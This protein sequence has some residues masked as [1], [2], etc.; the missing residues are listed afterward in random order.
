MQRPQTDGLHPA[1]HSAASLPLPPLGYSPLVTPDR[2]L[3]E[4]ARQERR[5]FAAA[6]LLG[7]LAGLAAIAA[8]AALARAVA[9]AAMSGATLAVLAP[10][11]ALGL[12]AVALRAGLGW[13]SEAL[14][15]GAAARI[16][17]RLRMRLVRHLA[18]A[19]PAAGGREQA[20]ELATVVLQGVDALDDGLARYLPQTALAVVVPLA[21]LSQV[22]VTDP[23]SALVLALTAPLIPLFAWLLGRWAALEARRRWRSLGRLG[24]AALDLIQG[25]DAVVLL[26]RA[27]PAVAR[28]TALTEDLRRETMAVLRVAFLSA[29]ALELVATLSTAVLA[30]A[31]GLRLL[32]GR[33]ELAQGLLVLLLAPELFAPLRRL[34]SSFHAAA[35]SVAALDRIDQLLALPVAGSPVASPQRPM[36]CPAPIRLEAVTVRYPPRGDDGMP[37]TALEELDLTLGPGQL[38]AVVGPSGAGKSTLAATL[39]RLVEPAAGRLLAGG[40]PTAEIDPDVWRA[41]FA[42]VP[43]TPLLLADSL[44]ANLR[45]AR[46]EADDDSL[47]E[48]CDAVGLGGLLAG[49]PAG[50]ATSI[51]ERGARLSGGQAR[52]LA[53]A[54]AVLSRAS[55][56][57]LDEA[58]EGLDPDT[59]ALVD[60]LLADRP[61][62]RAVLVIAHRLATARLA[63]RVVVLDRGRLVAQGPHEELLGSCGLYAAMVAGGGPV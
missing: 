21:V 20:G 51:G 27:R 14:A 48:A 28:V 50:L 17:H 44:A 25:L 15:L 58:T 7:S 33:L 60:R 40:V 11:L 2:R 63:D 30:V 61:P 13:G 1:P 23:L 38:V 16:R 45:L 35:G 32:H 36:P 10:S 53:L 41:A 3:L 49:L 8:A 57:V 4:L 62:D 56:W 6:I 26:G 55:V 43:Q 29:G 19:R 37:V 52:R 12:V 5:R 31:V 18:A 22:L 54:R 42:W 39:L 47:R 46:P 34:G 9:A 24:A 59:A